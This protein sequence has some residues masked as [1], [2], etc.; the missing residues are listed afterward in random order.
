MKYIIVLVCVLAL[1]QAVSNLL[2]LTSVLPHPYI[3][4]NKFPK[5][6]CALYEEDLTRGRSYIIVVF[7]KI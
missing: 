6:I 4:L 7:A 2:N 5:S 3:L 1:S